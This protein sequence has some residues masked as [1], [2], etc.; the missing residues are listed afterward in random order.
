[1]KTSEE[2][3]DDYLDNYN[4]LKITNELCRLRVAPEEFIANVEKIRA[5]G[6]ERRKATDYTEFHIQHSENCMI[7]ILLMNKLTK[8]E[9]IEQCARLQ[10]EKELEFAAKAPGIQ[11]KVKLIKL[12][13]M[14]KDVV[15]IYRWL[16]RK[17]ITIEMLSTEIL[18][19]FSKTR[20]YDYLL[21]KKIIAG[22]Q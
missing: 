22:P 14:F 15:N 19:S 13:L 21:K 11:Q 10:K 1:M 7:A 16:Y 12:P 3:L 5:F 4:A 2:Y 6:I 20:Q 18:A 8:E 17:Q 9:F